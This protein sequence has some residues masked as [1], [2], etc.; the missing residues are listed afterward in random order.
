MRLYKGKIPNIVDELLTELIKDGDVEV[1]N[2]EEARLDLEAVLTEF[3]RR[4]RQVMD[5]AR[6]R[7][8]REGM[9]YSMLGKMRSRVARETDFPPQDEMLPY[10]IDQ[11]LTMLFH[12][13]NVAEVF[14]DD[15]E[16][17]KK[18]API[19]RRHTEVETELDVEVRSKIKNLSEGTANFE[20]EYARVMEQMRRKKGLS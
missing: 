17:R 8:E 5:E 9:S 3:V 6:T 4:E 15:S 11:L 13:Q 20:I 12:S 14:A 7:M 19:I 2:E 10:I 18:M 16:L 1:E